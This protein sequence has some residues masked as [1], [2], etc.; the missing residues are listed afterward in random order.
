M[1]NVPQ[2]IEVVVEPLV[3]GPKDMEAL[4]MSIRVLVNGEEVSYKRIEPQDFLMSNFDLVF[5]WVK[6]EIKKQLEVKI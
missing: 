5:D 6:F 3:Y 1:K 4:L 2:R